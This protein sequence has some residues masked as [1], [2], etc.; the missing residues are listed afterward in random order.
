MHIDLCHRLKYSQWLFEEIFVW[1]TSVVL[2]YDHRPLAPS[3][4]SWHSSGPL[5]YE[6]PARVPL[7]N[8]QPAPCRTSVP[9]AYEWTTRDTRVPLVV[10]ADR[11]GTARA[12]AHC[13]SYT[14]S[15]YARAPLGVEFYAREFLN[16]YGARWAARGCHSEPGAFMRYDGYVRV[17][18]LIDSRDRERSDSPIVT[19]VSHRSTCFLKFF[20][21]PAGYA[22]TRVRDAGEPAQEPAYGNRSWDAISKI[23]VLYQAWDSYRSLLVYTSDT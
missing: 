5:V 17:L 3:W 12:C 9:F 11:E 1:H 18:S 16:D 8:K 2:A 7:A 21:A 10:R 23:N 4:S 14:S 15:S 19:R 20:P 13:E 6:Q 22:R